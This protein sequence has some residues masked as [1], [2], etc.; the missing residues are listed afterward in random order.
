MRGL[1]TWALACAVLALAPSV[2]LAGAPVELRDRPSVHG[3]SITLG[4][5]FEGADGAAGR[6]P[7][8]YSPAPG[9]EAVLDASR[10]QLIAHAA[11]LD[12]A[13]PQGLHR[14]VVGGPA[15][16]GA[17]AARTRS[18]AKHSQALVYARNIAANE[19]VGSAD[20]NWSDDAVA[21]S[22][23]PGDPDAAI[24]K[25]AR[26]PLRAGAVVQAR[27][28]AA[29]RVVK[30]DDMIL[31][32]FEAEGLTL[33]LQAKALADASVGDSIQVQNTA[34]KK[35]LEAVVTGPG[36]AAVGPRAEALK[37]AAFN[38]DLRTASLR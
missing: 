25:A 27:D 28:L 31:I 33:T 23:S 5:L 12:W 1:N 22:D 35:T 7:V 15:G 14:I 19:I 36:Q 32:A 30:R 34:S 3:P 24:G 10:V 6:H 9:A 17:P 21:A 11:G 38:P 16:G 18:A 4:D 2:A 29:P 37:A 13:N 8:G 20:L 26:R